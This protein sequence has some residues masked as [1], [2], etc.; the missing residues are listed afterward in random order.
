M[1]TILE[2][3]RKIALLQEAKENKTETVMHLPHVVERAI[4][5]KPH[6]A[7]AHLE[8]GLNTAQNLPTQGSWSDKADGGVSILIKKG[9]VKYKGENEENNPWVSSLEEIEQTYGKQGRGHLRPHLMAGLGLA[10]HP[11]M[12]EDV[13][14][15]GDT[16]LQNPDHP[17]LLKGNILNYKK[18]RKSVKH[19]VAVHTV[20]DSNT[21]KKI[22]TAPDIRHMETKDLFLPYLG[23][24]G[25]MHSPK[26]EEITA[27]NHHISQAKQIFSDPDVARV[28]KGIARH[29]D[30]SN[31]QGH[32]YLFFKQFNNAFQRGDF[33]HFST[34]DKPVRRSTDLLMHF[35]TM[36][37]ANAKSSSEKNRILGHLKYIGNNALAIHKMLEG[38]AHIDEARKHI[39]NITKRTPSDL[40]PVNPETGK[41]DYS[42]GEGKVS[43]V[44]GIEPVKFVESSFTSANAAQS[45]AAKAR[46]KNKEQI[47][48]NEGGAMMT[49]SSGAISGMGY[50]LGGPAPDDVAVAPLKNRM[51]SK[52]A[53]PFR[54]KLMRKLLGRINV[55]REAY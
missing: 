21:G 55:G 39:V 47:Q 46:K 33:N 51:A 50:N 28:V 19:G 22:D 34:K 36:K 8:N 53:K 2:A 3:F 10:H 11:E 48:E 26:P 25:K 41:V 15:Q 18:P 44:P 42:M 1:I 6:E 23:T 29:R 20:F 37:L 5:G 43:Y 9:A 24:K 30:P 38:H 13:M 32:R 35:T 45:A 40:H 4:L 7:I 14:Y 49:A 31:K 16:L 17:N 27:I 12:S 52:K 54:R